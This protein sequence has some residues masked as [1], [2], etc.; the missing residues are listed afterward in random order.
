[1]RVFS[2]VL[3]A[4]VALLSGQALADPENHNNFEQT[5]AANGFASE[6]YT[7]ISD[8]DY[9]YQLYRIPGKAGDANTKKPAVLLMHGVECDMMFWLPNEPSVT[10]AFVLAE[11][12]Y[13]V[14]L[15]NNRGNRYSNTHTTLD[16]TSKEYWDYYQ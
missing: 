4:A 7:V 8:D 15:G 16:N 14:W 1:M 2:A 11:Q 9:V 5:C 6:S 12:G 3:V 10:P 13:D